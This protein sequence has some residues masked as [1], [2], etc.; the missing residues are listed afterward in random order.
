MHQILLKEYV[1]VL[2]RHFE[3]IDLQPELYIVEWTLTLYSQV[4]PTRTAYRVWD[5][6]FHF[7]EQLLFVVA[8]GILRTL[9]P[10]LQNQPF[11]VVAAILTRGSEKIKP[12]VHE[13]V[14][15]QH[16]HSIRFSQKRYNDLLQQFVHQ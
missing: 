11:E 3:T 7:G 14:L 5:Y 13:E 12:L 1:P 10:F 9:L 15:F 4:L 2:Y 16:V 8:I 6:Y